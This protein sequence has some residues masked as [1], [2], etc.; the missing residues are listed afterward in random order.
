MGRIDFSRSLYRIIALLATLGASAP[1]PAQSDPV[2]ELVQGFMRQANVPG[3]AIAVVQGGRLVKAKGYGLAN[4]EHQV[5][6]TPSTVFQSASV[7]KQ[8]TA[9]EILLLAQDG[10]LALDDPISKYLTGTPAEWRA[11]TIR[12]LLTHTSGIGGEDTDWLDLRRDYSEAEL[13]RIIASHPLLFPPGDEWSYS[14][15]GYTLLG[16]IIRS[17]TGA[18]WGDFLK[19]RIFDPLGMMTARV[20]SE[21][22]I[23]PDRAAGYEVASGTIRNQAWVAPSHN[24]VA[25]GSLYVT[26][27]DLAKWD[28]A[29][30]GD[31]L[32]SNA[33]KE[34]MWAPVRL[35]DGTTTSHGMG[36]FLQDV[37]GRRA[38]ESSGAW[39]GFRTYIGRF[40][41]DSLTIIVLANSTGLREPTFFGHRIAALVRP[42]L[43]PPTVSPI[44]LSEEVLQEYVG[45][46]RTP[47]G[48]I[49]DVTRRGTGLDIVMGGGGRIVNHVEPEAKD[50]FFNTQLPEPRAIFVRDG[51]GTVRWLRL[52]L[53][54][55]SPE[56]AVRIG[57]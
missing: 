34:Q 45:K 42:R 53:F 33:S 57:Q 18:H 17:V 16:M 11:I 43:T 7:G 4:I 2:D 26:V 12:H 22:D 44:R 49:M 3:I 38:V 21:Q 28:A 5:A 39:Q 31:S 19:K 51:S 47:A 37:P 10:K 35:N 40:V 8:F 13:L 23:V 32:L 55:S 1:L 52:K 46:Y 9:A 6:V 24:T 27:L 20:I 36:W 50:V 14:N 15:A 54:P 30:Y 48:A 25:E 29:L 56:R 41:D